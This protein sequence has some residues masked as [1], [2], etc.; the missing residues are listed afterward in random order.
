MAGIRRVMME[1]IADLGQN[2]NGSIDLAK[3][4]IHS[5]KESGADV[6]KFQLFDAKKLFPKEN[7]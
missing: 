4:M 1:I 6:A 5:A 7:N 2:H 3:R